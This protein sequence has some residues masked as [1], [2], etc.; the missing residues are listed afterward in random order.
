MC[1]QANLVP[2][3][4]GE[5]HDTSASEHS[6]ADRTHE[7]QAPKKGQRRYIPAERNLTPGS[8]FSLMGYRSIHVPGDSV[9][10]FAPTASKQGSQA[11]DLAQPGPH[12][13]LL[14][15]K[16]SQVGKVGKQW[17]GERDALRPLQ[18]SR[19]DRKG[20]SCS[21]KIRTD[22]PDRRDIG[23]S[24]TWLLGSPILSGMGQRRQTFIQFPWPT[25]WAN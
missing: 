23:P 4:V 6:S 3:P 18:R 11:R 1:N 10:F 20:D 14:P 5:R 2:H 22:Q 21:E 8:S 24:Q 25:D 19:M 13:S 9:S 12:I 16:E 17:R 15:C 7:T